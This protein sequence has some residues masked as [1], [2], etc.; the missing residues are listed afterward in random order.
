M[1]RVENQN[2]KIN[3]KIRKEDMWHDTIHIGVI[4]RINKK[5]DCK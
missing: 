3:R 4:C 2:F 1:N 5:L